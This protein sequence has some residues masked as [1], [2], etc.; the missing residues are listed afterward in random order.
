MRCG[1]ELSSENFSVLPGF[2]WLLNWPKGHVGEIEAS[3]VEDPACGDPPGCPRP[4]PAQLPP[5]RGSARAPHGAVS[6]AMMPAMSG[7]FHS[8][9]ASPPSMLRMTAPSHAI[10][11]P[12]AGTPKNS[13]ASGRRRESCRKCGGRMRVLE[14][15]S[16]LDAI[17]RIL[18]GARAPPAPHP[19]GQLLLLP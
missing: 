2:E 13:A 19:P 3:A 15:V 9:T 16:D 11:R 6:W 10:A 17:A 14:V 18:H 5:F 12:V 8:S 7:A 1:Y 4:H